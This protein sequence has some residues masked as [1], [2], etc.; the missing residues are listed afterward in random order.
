MLFP[1][2]D[3]EVRKPMRL[4][5]ELLALAF[6]MLASVGGTYVATSLQLARIEERQ[7]YTTGNIQDVRS[8]LGNLELRVRELEN[9]QFNN[10]K[11]TL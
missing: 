6:A 4:T 1:P 8:V 9:D 11:N 3:T 7:I 5:T 2:A 10:K